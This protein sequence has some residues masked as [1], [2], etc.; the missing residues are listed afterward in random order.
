MKSPLLAVLVSG[1]ALADPPASPSNTPPPLLQDDAA[2]PHPAAT[3]PSDA[4]VAAPAPATT[5]APPATG[6]PSEG[7]VQQRWDHRGAIGVSLA[8]GVAFREG[9]TLARTVDGG[10][11][12]PVDVGVSVALPQTQN[13]LWA[14]GR[15]AFGAPIKEWSLR[16]GYRS[17]FGE[18]R[19]KTF[20]DLG[21]VFQV[22][23][24]FAA[25]ARVG[26]GV[27]YEFLPVGG[28]FAAA[29]VEV[30]GGNGFHFD[31]DITT[32]IELR[33]YLLE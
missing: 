15:V 20:L 27:M 5:Q 31:A 14:S 21:A 9:S 23:P 19:W 13:S 25:G 3:P 7:V 18:E 6:G 16:A 1:V 10:A 29:G 22:T 30:G 24:R 33:T 8:G 11:R 12:V 26:A 2:T 28:W 4:P 17:F 32:G